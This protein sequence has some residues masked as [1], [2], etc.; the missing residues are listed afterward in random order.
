MFFGGPQRARVQGTFG[1]FR[2]GNPVAV[3]LWLAVRLKAD[4]KC[5]IICPAW[6]R[7]GWYWSI[8]ARCMCCSGCC[9]VRAPFVLKGVCV[10]FFTSH[11]CLCDVPDELRETYATETKEELLFAPIPFHYLEI[12]SLILHA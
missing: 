10:R 4:S 9:L 8:L 5:N 1:P 6:M 7:A 11:C 12:S 2:P 3:P